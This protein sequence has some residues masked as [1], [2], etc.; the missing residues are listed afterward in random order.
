MTKVNLHVYGLSQHLE[1]QELALYLPPV[2]KDLVCLFCVAWML[3][4]CLSNHTSDI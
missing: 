4:Q 1:L 2:L 3:K